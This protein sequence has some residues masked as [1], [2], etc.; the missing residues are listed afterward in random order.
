[1]SD[2]RP[3]V[4]EGLEPSTT[5]LAVR[6]EMP[7]SGK[8]ATRGLIYGLGWCSVGSALVPLAPVIACV[9]V[10]FGAAVA[11]GTGSR[12]EQV[13]VLMAGLVAGLLS[14]YLHFGVHEVPNTELSVICAYVVAWAVATGRLHTGGL[15]GGVA[16]ITLVM[17][18]MDTL[19]TSLQGTSI[20][21][22]ITTVVDQVVEESIGTLDLEGVAEVLEAKESVIAMWPTI[23]FVVAA[24][25]VVC[26]LIGAKV[27]A[28]RDRK[29]VV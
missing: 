17:I 28:R 10:A 25:M 8:N 29:S 2:R 26:S 22:V 24:S 23:Y 27:G 9:L 21:E 14:S 20:N 1:M 6:E 11:I 18:G 7:Q 12:R 15:V 3:V 13:L 4:P 5:Q 16:A 19:S